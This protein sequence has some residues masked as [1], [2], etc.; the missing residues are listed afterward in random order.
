MIEMFSLKLWK[1]NTVSKQ[2]VT[3]NTSH[4]ML[5]NYFFE[6]LGFF[7]NFYE[8]FGILENVMKCYEMLGNV[9]KF[10]KILRFFFKCKEVLEKNRKM[11]LIFFQIFGTETHHLPHRWLRYRMRYQWQCWY[12][13]VT[14]SPMSIYTIILSMRH[15]GSASN[16]ITEKKK[17]NKKTHWKSCQNR[18]GL[19]RP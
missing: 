11:F 13:H 5:Y 4:S 12:L 15:S 9:R 18:H 1:D 7:W 10:L 8:I 17:M 19:V 2:S 6:M 14:K 16:L 3:S